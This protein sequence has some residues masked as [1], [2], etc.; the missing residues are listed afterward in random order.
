VDWHSQLQHQHRGPQL[1]E[2]FQDCM[3]DSGSCW[4]HQDPQLLQKHLP[5][6]DKGRPHTDFLRPFVGV[7]EFEDCFRRCMASI[8]SR[9]W[10]SH[11]SFGL[12][13]RCMGHQRIALP[14]E[15]EIGLEGNRAFAAGRLEPF[16]LV[17]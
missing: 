7:L 5:T 3:E 8:C 15:K 6:L 9:N 1:E 14:G 4:S 13:G 10:S 12:F 16:V 17:G 11:L 2:C